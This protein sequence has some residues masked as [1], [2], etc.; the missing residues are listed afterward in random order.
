[1]ISHCGEAGSRWLQRLSMV[2]VCG[3]V[4]LWLCVAVCGCVRLCVAMLAGAGGIMNSVD[5]VDGASEPVSLH[6]S[7]V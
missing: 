2:A 1:M 6:A 5:G 4:W 7:Q 3:C